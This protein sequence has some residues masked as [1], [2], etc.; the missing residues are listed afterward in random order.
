MGAG[1]EGPCLLG[2][3]AHT[4]LAAWTPPGPLGRRRHMQVGLTFSASQPPSAPCPAP[5]WHVTTRFFSHP[6]RLQASSEQL[7]GRKQNE[8]GLQVS[9]SLPGGLRVNKYSQSREK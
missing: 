3:R 6:A 8:K 9:A 1:R 4:A 7:H 5:A 2:A